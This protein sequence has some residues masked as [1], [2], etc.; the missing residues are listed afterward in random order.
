MSEQRK[1]VSEQSKRMSEQPW[2]QWLLRGAIG[3]AAIL[4]LAVP[5]WA[6]R[7]LST[8]D[9]F[10]VRRIEFDGVR[11][12][13]PSELVALL[14]IDTTESVWMALDPLG[15]RVREHPM[16]VHAVVTRR[17]PATL[18][19]TVRER[20]PIALA[21]SDSGLV[22]VDSAGASLPIDPSRTPVDVPIIADAD[23][24]LLRL[25]SQLRTGAPELW[26][27]LA[28]A[29]RENTTD[30][31]L[32]FG[33]IDLRTRDDVTIARLADILPVEADL[34][35]RRLQAVELDLRFRDQVIARLP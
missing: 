8:L 15:E 19:V 16:V 5:W 29:K 31:R 18:V 3:L 4:L 28:S 22:P 23:T 30:F 20:S 27:R 12:S 21:P 17:L 6:P 13:D 14:A 1:R 2:R 26:T 9:F 10:H 32:S 24:A 7:V 33:Q 35:R 25:L 34:A 11:Y